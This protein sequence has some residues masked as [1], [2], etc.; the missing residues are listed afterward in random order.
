MFLISQQNFWQKWMDHSW[1]MEVE[2]ND[3]SLIKEFQENQEKMESVI[4][5]IINTESNPEDS[6]PSQ[7]DPD[8][9]IHT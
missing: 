1:C 6:S 3:K 8:Q 2:K 4:S 7:I 9:P 5:E